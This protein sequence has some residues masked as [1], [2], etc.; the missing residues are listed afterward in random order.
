[1]LFNSTVYEKNSELWVQQQLQ[2]QLQQQ[3]Q[4]Q[5]Q[6]PTIPKQLS[7]QTRSPLP[8]LIPNQSQQQRSMSPNSIYSALLHYHIQQT[9]QQ[10]LMLQ[11]QL[12]H[13]NYLMSEL[14]VR[15]LQQH[16][17]Q[18]QI[19]QQAAA[20]A[21]AQQLT[22]KTNFTKKFDEIHPST[23]NNAT[24]L[25]K[26][27]DLNSPASSISSTSS[28]LDTL[29]RVSSSSSSS[30][31]TSSND[32]VLNLKQG[33]S[34][35]RP[36][37]KFSMDAILGNGNNLSNNNNNN[38]VLEINETKSKRLCVDDM[39][40]RQENNKTPLATSSSQI[41]SQQHSSSSSN[42]LQQINNNNKQ[43][44]LGLVSAAGLNLK[45]QIQQ[46][47]QQL[48]NNNNPLFPI[49]LGKLYYKRTY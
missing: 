37:L 22:L 26:P 36:Y 7:N 21:A 27:N 43:A 24:K 14:G 15:N 10:E 16:S 3:Q 11:Q 6:Q 45:N 39:N 31:S 18:F 32:D 4:Q 25:I 35:K 40:S 13:E 48:S 46:Q 49:G 20:L 19:I 47:Q 5:Q 17:N 2:Q 44:N 38:S 34:L 1:M 41:E 33:K 30:S 23:D 42:R 12:R 28:S 29:T 9:H 8:S